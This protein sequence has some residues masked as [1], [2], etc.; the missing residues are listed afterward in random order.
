MKLSD[1]RKIT[2]RQRMRV[3]FALANGM[4]CVIDEHGLA[5]VPG[6]KAPPDFNLED[7]LAG[8]TRFEMQP[9]EGAPVS[10]P[11]S[12]LERL[13]AGGPAEASREED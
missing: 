4:H 5:R 2:V 10:V 8:A 7:E 12:E 1:I 9:L 6:L 3:R 11:R 13:A